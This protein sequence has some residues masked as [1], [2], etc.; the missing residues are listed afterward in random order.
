MVSTKAK[1]EDVAVWTRAGQKGRNREVNNISKNQLFDQL[2]EASVALHA[3]PP[4]P[5]ERKR[6]HFVCTG[7][8]DNPMP[9]YLHP[10]DCFLAFHKCN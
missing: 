3:I 6:T 5:N 2:T 8:P 10:K 9:T 1:V 7:C 4:E